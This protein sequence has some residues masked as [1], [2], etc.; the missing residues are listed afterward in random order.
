VKEDR[1]KRPYVVWFHVYGLSRT[2][3]CIETGSGI[4]IAR[5]W[6]GRE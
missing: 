4:V 2:G 3:K 6:G 1:H 5:G